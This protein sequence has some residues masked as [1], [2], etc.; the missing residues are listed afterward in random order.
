[1][2]SERHGGLL[3]VYTKGLVAERLPR[4]SKPLLHAWVCLPLFP[5]LKADD[6]QG[7]LNGI[8]EVLQGAGGNGLLRRV[9]AGAIRLCEEGNN[10]LHTALCA[11]CA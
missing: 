6:M 2:Y 5:S 9:L 10:H 8:G 7:V 4:C 1:M 11:Q 3:H